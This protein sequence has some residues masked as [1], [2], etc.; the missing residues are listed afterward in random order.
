MLDNK[1][2][3]KLECLKLATYTGC[4]DPLSEAVRYFSWVSD[5]DSPSPPSQVLRAEYSEERS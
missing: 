1:S 3:I 2:T 5:T 4:H